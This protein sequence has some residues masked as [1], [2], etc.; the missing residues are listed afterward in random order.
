MAS[1]SL[2]A[3]NKMHS[4]IKLSFMVGR[5]V[6]WNFIKALRLHNKSIHNMI[7]EFFQYAERSELLVGT[8][9]A[10]TKCLLAC[11]MSN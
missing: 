7:E 8:S 2:T 5:L 4:P 3:A 11:S 10:S 9:K 6:D 1:L